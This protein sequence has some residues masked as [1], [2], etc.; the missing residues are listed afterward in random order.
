ML[1]D[2]WEA[3]GTVAQWVSRGC[4]ACPRLLLDPL[5]S[6]PIPLH[7]PGQWGK[8]TPQPGLTSVPGHGREWCSFSLLTHPEPSWAQ[9][10]LHTHRTGETYELQSLRLPELSTEGSKCFR[11]VLPLEVFSR[12]ALF[13]SKNTETFLIQLLVQLIL[14]EA[15]IFSAFPLVPCLWSI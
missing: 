4:I 6:L 5:S 13:L 2:C 12:H 15:I 9:L 8:H 14:H 1:R 7:G 11:R 10:V 3:V